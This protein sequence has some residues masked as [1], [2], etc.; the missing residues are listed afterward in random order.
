MYIAAATF[1]QLGRSFVEEMEIY[2]EVDIKFMELA[3]G[4]AGVFGRNPPF[5]G[6][7]TNMISDMW[8]K[9]SYP[10]E[11]VDPATGWPSW[12]LKELIESYSVQVS[13]FYHANEPLLYEPVKQRWEIKKVKGLCKMANKWG[14]KVIRIHGG[15]PSLGVDFVQTPRPKWIGGLWEMGIEEVIDLIV[16]QFKEYVKYAEEYDVDLAMENHFAILQD[17]DRCIRIIN[18]VGSERLGLNNDTGNWFYGGQNTEW[19]KE[20]FLKLAPYTK[21][22][23]IKD[24]KKSYNPFQLLGP[25]ARIGWG[26]GTILGHGEVPIKNCIRELKKVGYKGPLNIHGGCTDP[27]VS[28]FEWFKQ[29]I[30]YVRS[31]L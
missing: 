10:W 3:V 25:M 15:G 7:T 17:A 28:N 16:A 31:C 30:E 8:P 14:V 21:S 5:R 13:S 23:H 19:M 4:E 9:G 18:E 27:K 11:Y 1:G 26:E 24:G 20:A 22:T 2:N 12:E 29:S 6:Y